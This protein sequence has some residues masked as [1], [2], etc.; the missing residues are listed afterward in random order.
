MKT[1]KVCVLAMALSVAAPS[2]AAERPYDA[3]DTVTCRTASSAQFVECRASV[4][5]GED[6]TATI[7]IEAPGGLRRTIHYQGGQPASSDG[8]GRVAFDRNRDTLVVRV[9]SAEVYEIPD[10]LIRGD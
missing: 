5:R 1:P 8:D 6:G 2:D 9:G 10:R 4:I 3:V 7:L